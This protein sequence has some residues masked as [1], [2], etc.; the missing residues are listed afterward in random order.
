MRQPPTKKLGPSLGS[1]VLVAGALFAVLGCQSSGLGAVCQLAPAIGTGAAYAID[2]TSNA[3]PSHVCLLPAQQKTTDTPAL[4]SQ[5]CKTDG[6]CQG[7]EARNFRDATDHRCQSGFTCQA[8]T[9][10]A[11]MSAT[12]PC[13][14]MCVCADFLDVNGPPPV[15][16]S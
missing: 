9:G 11:D 8:V 10:P 16:C 14:K 6:D 7:G 4:C 12:G 1:S 5:S 2:A 13:Q 15:S 3:C